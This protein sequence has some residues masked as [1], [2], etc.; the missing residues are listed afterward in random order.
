ML[1]T[2]AEAGRKGYAEVA[3]GAEVV[4]ASRMAQVAHKVQAAEVEVVGMVDEAVATPLV[5]DTTRNSHK[6]SAVQVLGALPEV[7]GR[8]SGMMRM[9]R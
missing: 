1:H 5:L 6:R 8:C 9:C 3:S 2:V 4:E 7:A